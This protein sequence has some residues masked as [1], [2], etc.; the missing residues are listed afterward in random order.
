MKFGFIGGTPRGFTLFKELLAKGHKPEFCV[1]LK[2]DDHENTKISN[3]FLQTASQNAVPSEIKK[4]LEEKDYKMIRELSPDFI[5]VCGWRTLIKTEVNDH[6]KIGLVAA[7][8]SLLPKYRGFAPLNWAIINGEKK[9]GVTLF[10]INDGETDSGDIIH[11]EEVEIAE[12]DYAS[13][14]YKKVIDATVSSYLH[15][16]QNVA[17]GQMINRVKQKESEATYTCKRTP[18]DGQINWNDSSEKVYNLVRALAYPYS[19]AFFYHNNK[20]YEI[21][22]ASPGIQ[23]NKHFSG[24]IPGRI[25]SIL[26]NGI[27]VMCGEG[28][29]MINE[30]RDENSD[31]VIT[32]NQVFKSIT[33]RLQ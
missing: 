33:I 32:A 3:E 14:V 28:T 20:K 15:F 16:I 23:N 26:N 13:D 1:I 5:I 12:N 29:V 22:S 30:I 10:I 24:R 27:E 4:K 17:S 25:I 6:L 19:G 2:E 7:H 8:D 11:Q 31:S 9:T 21:R 18:E